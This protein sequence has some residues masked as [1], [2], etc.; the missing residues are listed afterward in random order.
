MAQA[1][2]K[3]WFILN[4]DL[5]FN[6]LVDA[7]VAGMY[8]YAKYVAKDFRKLLLKRPDGPAGRRQ[9]RKALQ[10]MIK[11]NMTA[12][13]E[14]VVASI[15]IDE[16]KLADEVWRTRAF[17]V[18]YGSGD[19]GRLG[20]EPLKTRPGEQTWHDD[21]SVRRESKAR[22][23]YAMP[24]NYNH[25]GNDAVELTK[26]KTEHEQRAMIARFIKPRVDKVLRHVDR[27]IS[28]QA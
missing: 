25:V 27:Y 21:L 24:K 26:A 4:E 19:R 12:D 22:S 6:D 5:L 14:H 3:S 11:I 7:I 8:D 20:G 16:N 28:F 10:D 17:V 15:T 2:R 9:W 1:S 13:E 23:V 18:V